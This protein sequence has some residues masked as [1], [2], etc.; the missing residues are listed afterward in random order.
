MALG[1][2]ARSFQE[3]RNDVMECKL[4]SITIHY[5]VMG[6]GMPI[7]MLHG[8]PADHHHMVSDMEPLFQQRIGWKRFYPDLPGMGKTSGTDWITTQDQMLDV[9]LSF[10]DKVIPGQRFVV[11]GTSY[12]GYLARGI[13]YRKS[14][15]MNGL[16]LMVPQ[17]QADY[18]KATLPSHI[19]LV[20]DTSIFSGVEP[21]IAKV[22][23]G[24]AVVQS[25]Q[26]LES[27]MAN[28]FPAAEIA[29]SKFLEK[30]ENQFSFDVDTLPEPFSAPTLILTGRQD[31]SC[32]YY[33]AWHILENYP[34]GTFV[35]LD[36]AGHG[37]GIE[38]ENLFRTLASEWLDRVEE[39]IRLQS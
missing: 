35:V 13:V 34:R 33:D 38:Q 12:G 39:F 29:D 27:M 16:L 10:I 22:I 11:A 24:F 31:S 1:R 37:L 30:L 36:R 5:E 26:M 23:Q 18:E 2:W 7:V 25:K 32:G 14:P 20:E 17:I 9:A 4:E 19:T 6:E 15:L 28:L 3:R 21:N 8:L